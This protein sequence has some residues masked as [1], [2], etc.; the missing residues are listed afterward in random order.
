MNIMLLSVSVWSGAE[1]ETRQAFH[2]IS[3][4]LAFPAL[5]YS[6]RVFFASAW[7]A[8]AAGPHQYGRADLR[9][10][11][12]GLRAE[13]LR[14]DGRRRLCLFRRCG[15][16]VVL[17]ADRPDPRPYDARKGAQRRA[18]SDQAH[19]ARRD[20]RTRGRQ[21]RLSAGQPD[22]DRHACWRS[23]RASA[24]WSTASSSGADPISIARWSAA[25]ARR[26]R[27]SRGRPYAPVR[28]TSPAP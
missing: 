21:P 13:P 7:S 26:N 24:C 27:W 1:P 12:P 8:L 16:A 14:H 19:A 25:R 20:G 10:R 5:L 6:G 9:R 23:R 2:W 4:A 22:R 11:H 18:R 3:A 15:V 17:P 28:S